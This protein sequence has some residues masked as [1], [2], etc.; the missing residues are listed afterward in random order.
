M[1]WQ[2]SGELIIMVLLG[3]TRHALW[4]DPRRARLSAAG[5]RP[6]RLTEHWKVIFGPLLVLMVLFA[7]G[8]IAGAIE[9]WR[10]RRAEHRPAA[11]SRSPD[12]SA[13]LLGA[14]LSEWRAR[15]RSASGF[16]TRPPALQTRL[17]TLAARSRDGEIWRSA[18]ACVSLLV[19]RA[20][21]LRSRRALVAPMSEP[22]LRLEPSSKSFGA[23][24]V[25]EPEPRDPARRNARHHRPERRR[26]DHADQPDLRRA[27]A[28]RGP[29]PSSTAATSPRCRCRARAAG[30]RALVPDHARAA[31]LLGA[32]E[33]G[34]RRAGALGLE[35]SLLAAAAGEAALNRAAVGC[36]DSVELAS[37]RRR[38]R[39][40]AVARR[41]AP[42]R[43]RHRAGAGAQAAPARRADGR[44]RHRGNAAPGRHAQSA[45]RAATPSCSSST[46]CR[47]YLRWPTASRCWSTAGSSPPAR[48]RPCAPIRPCAPPT[49]ARR[50]ESDAPY[51]RGA[52]GRL[53]RIA[54]PVRLRSEVGAGEVVSLLGRNGMGKTTTVRA[55]MGLLR[56]A[57]GEHRASTAAHA[58]APPFR[59]AQAGIGLVPEGRQIFPTLTVEEN[60]VATAADRVAAAKLDAR[61][62]LRVLAAA[63]RAPP[64]LR[65]P[66]LRRRAADAGDR[67]RPDDQSEAADP[68]RGYGRSGAADPPGHSLAI[69][70]L[71]KGEEVGRITWSIN[72]LAGH[73]GLAST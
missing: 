34:A 7:R 20:R 64:Q 25:T 61:A 22:V 8:G 66:A 48:Q 71:W 44:R 60:L 63:G 24:R 2:R 57:A 30:S 29:H 26:Q 46:I 28:G 1:H 33:R 27:R 5:G 50:H 62:R 3:G 65:R 39:R 12:G 19:G 49:L 72:K 53:R 41:K 55:M 31:A 40:R 4:R 73:C 51:R 16:S 37:A 69:R 10:R 56:A 14:R 23:L 9:R 45:S 67:P 32:G 47:L 58:G 70:Q 11:R 35:L 36:L 59:I 15:S 17:P 43:D 13:T 52:A 54:G 18:A 21:H 6:L 68:R 38:P 42:A